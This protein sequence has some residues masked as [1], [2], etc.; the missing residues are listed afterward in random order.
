MKKLIIILTIFL[1]SS[2]TT[3]NAQTLKSILKNHFAA[4]GQSNVNQAEAIVMN[5][6]INQMGM[7][8]PFVIYQKRPG[9]VR[10]EAAFQEMKIIQAF[11]GKN[12]WTINPMS[13]TDATDMGSS[14]INTMKDMAEIEGRL[15]NWKKKKYKVTYEGNEDFQEVKTYK[16][17]VVTP[18]EDVET[19]FLRS[20][21]YLIVKMDSKNKIQGMDVEATK[22]FS[23]YREI[24]GYM[25]PFKV[26]I[27]MMGQSA[28]EMDLTSFEIK[29]ANEVNDDLFVKPVTK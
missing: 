18:N 3:L 2:M 16:I 10:F 8:L 21:N 4:I 13:G 12:G 5:G 25:T 20:D 29:K 17:K 9:K 7:E 24:G 22:I 1:I 28:V 15:Y 11:D 26:E 23:D 19:Y 27:M 6:K 14:E